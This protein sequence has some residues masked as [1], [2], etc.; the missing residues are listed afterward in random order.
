M[1]FYYSV[2]EGTENALVFGKAHYSWR[3]A[4]MHFTEMLAIKGVETELLRAP[5]IYDSPIA[6]QQFKDA[7]PPVHAI[8]RPFDQVR[9]LKP[10]Y[11]IGVIVWEFDEL[12]GSAELSDRHDTHPF[13]N[14]VRMLATLNEVWTASTYAQKV[15]KDAGIENT[16]V[17]PAPIAL[18][19]SPRAGTKSLRS[20]TFISSSTLNMSHLRSPESNILANKHT[21]R[22]LYQQPVLQGLPA[23]KVYLSILNPGDERKNLNAM[24]KSFGGFS[25]KNP[26]AILIIKCSIDNIR[27]TLEIVQRDTIRAKLRDTVS[28][29]CPNVILISAALNDEQLAELYA[30]ADFYLCTSRCEGQN[31]PLLEAMASGVIPVSTDNTAMADYID[32]HNSFVIESRK[33]AVDNQNATAHRDK[34]LHWYEAD[35]YDTLRALNASAAADEAML[36][37]KSSAAVKTVADKFGYDAIFNLI[38]ERMGT[39]GKKFEDGWKPNV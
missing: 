22:P 16:H 4:S 28:L 2:P 6:A 1:R 35:E 18:P 25:K 11:N 10:G 21:T 30:L 19:A 12:S 37:E 32:Q 34:P 23:K 29:A 24:L 26:D 8:F 17:I 33:V 9:L 36:A 31:L 15:F 3:I 5:H 13:H 20:L 38:S 27:T 7:H 14:Q 39:I